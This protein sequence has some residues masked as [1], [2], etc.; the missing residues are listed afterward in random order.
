MNHRFDRI[1]GYILL[2]TAHFGPSV[3]VGRG[4]QIHSWFGLTAAIRDEPMSFA[5][6]LLV[7]AIGFAF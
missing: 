6:A 4:M 7:L 3:H 2:V 1:V 5:A